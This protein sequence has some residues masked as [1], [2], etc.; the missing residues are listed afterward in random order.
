MLL[1]LTHLIKKDLLIAKRVVIISMLLT[2][3]IPIFAL[4]LEP[5]IPGVLPFIY[6]VI[7]GE[8]MLLQTI[9]HKEQ[10]YPKA[11][12]L[13]CASPYERKAFVLAK[14]ILF[15][16]LFLYSS[17]AYTFVAFCMS[18]SFPIELT[19]LVNPTIFL[20]VLLIGSVFFGAYMPLD[21]KYG[22]ATARF[23]SNIAI[24]L[25]SLGPILFSQFFGNL[26]IGLTNLALTPFTVNC[27][28][29]LASFLIIVI[30]FRIS[31]H[32]FTNKDL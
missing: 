30:S 22:F 28:F 23:A 19:A 6:A 11:V 4:Y 13:L 27:T 15:I 7:F 1:H 16:L 25:L 8:I 29:A 10:T 20:T 21:F 18:K 3:A 9:A 24:V 31:M 14:Y 5:S 2:I 17:A 26:S 12:A 32:V